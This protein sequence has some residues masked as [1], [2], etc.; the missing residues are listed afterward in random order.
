MVRVRFK[1]PDYLFVGLGLDKSFQIYDVTSYVK[2]IVKQ[3][4]AQAFWHFLLSHEEQ[5]RIYLPIHHT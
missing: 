1:V 4:H 2:C 3:C 5:N